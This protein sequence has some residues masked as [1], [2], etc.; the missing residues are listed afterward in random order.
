MRGLTTLAILAWAVGCHS[1]PW[2]VAKWNFLRPTP[3]L[4]GQYRPL[5]STWSPRDVTITW[6]GQATVLINLHGTTILTDPVLTKRIAPPHLIG[7][8]NLG[9][10]RISELPLKPSD[11]PPIDLVLL[12]HAHYDHWDAASLKYFGDATTAIVPKGDRDLVPRGSFGCVHELHWG[13]SATVGPVDV[14]ASE[15]EHWGHRGDDP[16]HWRGYN[17]YVMDGHGIRI[18]FAGDTAFRK[19]SGPNRGRPVDWRARVGSDFDIC[20]LPI[21]D[22]YYP[23]NHITPEEAWSIFR[24]VRGQWLV[25]IHWRTFILCPPERVPI[26]EPITRLKQAAGS[27][28]GRIVCEE[29]GQVFVLPRKDPTP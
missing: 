22:Y 26:W 6:L 17:G 19:R 11:L 2:Q 14:T 21:G 23:A 1:Y 4:R 12:S 5:P 18:L 16:E 8:T 10:R 7:H 3:Y 25:P 15:V 9:I 28:A 29:P 27:E 13:E 24:Q 20:V